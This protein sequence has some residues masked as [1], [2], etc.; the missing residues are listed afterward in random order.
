MGHPLIPEPV[1]RR[2][3]ILLNKGKTYLE[4]AN[5]LAV[6]TATVNRV[7]RR[8]RAT[9]ET[10]APPRKGGRRSSITPDQE[11]DFRALVESIPDSTF[12]ELTAAWSR[13]VNKRVSRSAVLRKVR[14]LGY[15][16]KKKSLEA[17]EKKSKKNSAK[18]ASF[19]H[20][21]RGLPAEKLVFMDEAG[22]QCKLK[23]VRAR[24]I[25]GQRATTYASAAPST[26]FTISGAVRLNGPVVMRGDKKSMTTLRF[27]RFLQSALLPGLSPG[28]ILVMDNLSA[29]RNK[30]VR[31]L[32]RQWDVRVVYLPPYSPEYNPIEKVWAWMKNRLRARLNRATHCFR[33]AVAGA[34]RKASVPDYEKHLS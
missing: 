22:F 19:R 7:W 4:V 15:T 16:L 11:K 23:R 33:Y 27:L 34:W 30:A 13:K 31:R 32:C 1:R 17:T 24:A 25:C 8:F 2:I 29:H 14:K 5:S 12:D 3:V 10:T 21:R 6:G 18:R 9:G 28:D 26:N 20:L